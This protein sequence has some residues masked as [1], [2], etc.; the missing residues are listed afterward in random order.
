L[1]KSCDSVA[2]NFQGVSEMT[3]SFADEAFGRLL[4]ELGPTVFKQKVLLKSAT[5][6]LRRL[7]NYVLAHREKEKKD[8]DGSHKKSA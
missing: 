7:V 2:I 3:P 6:E 4:L 5:V 1:V 8:Q